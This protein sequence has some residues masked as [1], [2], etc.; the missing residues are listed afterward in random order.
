MSQYNRL[1]NHTRIPEVDKDSLLSF[2]DEAPRHMVVMRNG[3][4]YSLDAVQENGEVDKLLHV[5]C[6]GR[7]RCDVCIHVVMSFGSVLPS[8]LI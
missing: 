3:H 6:F 1:F 8:H 4:F 5:Q 7:H 2:K